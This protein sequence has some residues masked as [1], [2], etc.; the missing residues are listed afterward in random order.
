M[1]RPRLILLTL[2]T[3]GI[4]TMILRQG[5][6][7]RIMLEVEGQSFKEN[8]LVVPGN[9]SFFETNDPILIET[10]GTID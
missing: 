2:K 5:K 8:K 4:V 10:I 1:N 7:Y 6:E 9:S 3:T